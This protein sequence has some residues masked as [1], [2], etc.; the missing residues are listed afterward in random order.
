MYKGN[1]L[2]HFYHIGSSGKWL[3]PLSEHIHALRRYGLLE[4]LD[5]INFGIIGLSDN[6]KDV[7]DYLHKELDDFNIVA[8]TWS[9][10]ITF[11]SSE[12]ET[13][14]TD[15]SVVT[16]SSYYKDKVSDFGKILLAIKGHLLFCF[17]YNMG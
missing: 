7:K 5:S 17:H 16:L 15:G 2:H 10:G 4:K 11:W 12:L 6:R 13:T 14:T 3:Q 9:T 8:S 1:E